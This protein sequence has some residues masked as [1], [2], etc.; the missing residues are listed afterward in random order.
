MN[1]KVSSSEIRMFP[2]IIMDEASSEGNNNNNPVENPQ[3]L[4][5]NP[6][7]SSSAPVLKFV[8]WFSWRTSAF[9]DDIE[10]RLGGPECPLQPTLSTFREVCVWIHTDFPSLCVTQ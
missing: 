7:I 4:R 8:R 5:E 2:G 10:H 1:K 6:S 9:S 3:L